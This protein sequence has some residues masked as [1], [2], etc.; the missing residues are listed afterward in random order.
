MT[1]NAVTLAPYY[2]INDAEAFRK[3]WQVFYDKFPHK[4]DCV[5]YAFC[6]T[7]DGRAHCRQAYSNAAKVIQHLADVE[8]ALKEALDGP[9]QLER[10]E[11]HG[12]KHEIERLREELSTFSRGIIFYEAEWGNRPAR[13]AM[14]N[15]TVCHLYPYFKLKQP[16]E[17]RR[18]WYDAFP[19]TLAKQDIEDSHQYAFSF[20]PESNVASCRESYADAE[21][22][23]LHLQNVDKIL[24]AVLD[25]PA[26]LLRLEVHAPASEIEKLKV[27]L[28][29]LGCEFFAT[30][31][32]FRNAVGDSHLAPEEFQEAEENEDNEGI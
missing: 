22:V 3:I 5:H 9:A 2:K 7:G 26:E 29:P 12:P 18:I 15:D 32:G 28:S 24:T 13:P 23:L 31:W 10:I 1:D 30:E 20:N 27:D 6:F 21:G 16:Q 25:G 8:S 19:A 14:D 11:V 17:F 4:E